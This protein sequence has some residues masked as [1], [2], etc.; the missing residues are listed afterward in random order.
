MAL[1]KVPSNLDATVATTQSASDNSTNVAT[2]AYVTTALSN[3]VDSSPSALNTLNELAAALG[4]DANFSTTVTNS[5][6]TKSPINNPEFTGTVKAAQSGN[7]NIPTASSGN[8]DISFDGSNFTIV[9]NSSSA[10]LKL[11]TNSQDAV[12]IAANGNTTFAG[13]ISSGVINAFSASGGSNLSY[14]SNFK[15]DGANVQITLERGNDATGWGGIGANTSNAFMVYNQSTQ[16][17]LSLTQAGNLTV[18][19]TISSGEAVITS[20]SAT[21]AFIVK[22]NHSGNPT[23]L[24]IGGSGAINGISSSNQ[25]FTVLNVG[26]DTGSNNS[27]YFHGNVKLGGNL[28]HASD[29]AIDVP[30]AITLDAGTGGTGILLKDDGAQYGNLKGNSGAPT[31]LVIDSSSVAGY[32]SVAGTEYFAWNTTDIRPTAN[33]AYDLGASGAL[34]RNLKLGNDAFIDHAVYIGGATGAWIDSND[35]LVTNGRASLRGFGYNPLSL[36]RYNSGATAGEAGSMCEFLYGGGG[37]GSISITTNSTQYNTTSDVRLKDN[38]KTIVDG[39]SKIMAMN[40]VSHT[41]KANPTEDAVH[42][43]IAQEMIDI[44]PEAVAGEPEDEEMMQMDYGRI[45]PVI[46]AGLQDALK[47]IEKLK[48]R[49]NELEN[50]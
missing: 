6:A 9:S 48:E 7:F 47:E 21:N 35:A 36:G 37:V 32:L 38:I 44:I 45:T 39:S 15:A 24:Q 8:A 25:S 27:A 18:A 31:R 20:A 3:L 10:N 17:K 12:T 2:T 28:T 41:W 43:F 42:G 22:T 23:A 50:K 16:E 1:T 19:G 11:Q 29:L 30:G 34:F 49:I 5:I 40:P 26:K 14:A 4:D 46:V 33:N 13:T